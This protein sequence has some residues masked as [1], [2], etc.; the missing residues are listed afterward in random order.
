M[1]TPLLIAIGTAW[2]AIA[3]LAGVIIGGSIDLADKLDAAL[4]YDVE[5]EPE[6]LAS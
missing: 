6:E 3:L 1:N 5:I 2:T 4:T